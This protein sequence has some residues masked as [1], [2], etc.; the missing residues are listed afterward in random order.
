MQ[1]QPKPINYLFFLP[2]RV[3]TIF[4]FDKDDFIVTIDFIELK[5]NLLNHCFRYSKLHI[6]KHIYDLTLFRGG[7]VIQY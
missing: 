2:I 7:L 1:S 3:A 5:D 6:T 4:V